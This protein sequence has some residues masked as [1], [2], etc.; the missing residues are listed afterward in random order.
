MIFLIES[1]RRELEE[2]YQIRKNIQDP[3][4]PDTAVALKDLDL[5]VLTHLP[6]NLDREPKPKADAKPTK[7]K[8]RNALLNQ[9]IAKRMMKTVVE[10]DL[11]GYSTIAEVLEQALGVETSP[12]LNAQIQE[13]VDQG[14][15]VV[16]ADRSRTVMQT[17]GDGAILVFDKPKDVHRF[18]E[19][20]H[21]ATRE[22]NKTKT[23]PIGKRVFRIGIATGELVIQPKP[24]G[25]FDIAGMTIVR[26]VRMEA[27]ATPGG[28]LVDAVTF[29]GLAAEEQ[30]QYGLRETIRGKRDEKFDAYGCVLN[31]NG[32]ED[33]RFFTGKAT[34]IDTPKPCSTGL[35]DKKT[36]KKEI[37][38]LF[39]RVKTHQFDDL[40][41]VLDMPPARRPPSTLPL[42]KRKTYILEWAEEETEG[43][44]A[45]LVELR[46]VICPGKSSMRQD[47]FD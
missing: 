5:G 21:V 32:T 40:V 4:L 22:H 35:D 15:K 38:S 44:Q 10:L 41:F 47:D 30:K 14:L 28:V 31:A 23:K 18:A 27:K 34:E 42:E 12:K 6:L 25:G 20:V 11:V 8:N 46:E 39:K 45:L 7:L 33:A 37:L 16:G 17:T 1:A 19:A 2:S 9:P 24:G 43:L 29:E 13:F 26:A 3:R 36:L